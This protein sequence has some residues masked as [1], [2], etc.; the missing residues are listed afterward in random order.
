MEQRCNRVS[1]SRPHV[2]VSIP[3]DMQKLTV[4]SSSFRP[5]PPHRPTLRVTASVFRGSGGSGSTGTAQG[6]HTLRRQGQDVLLTGS[7]LRKASVLANDA[8]SGLVGVE[9]H[10][11]RL[12]SDEPVDALG[13][14]GSGQRS[15]VAGG[16]SC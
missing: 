12:S 8:S 13:A 11:Q 14:W 15:G 5:T 16:D 3:N 2:A 6:A 4:V 10:G 9:G 1:Q 7:V